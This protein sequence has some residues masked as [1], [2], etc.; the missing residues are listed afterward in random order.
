MLTYSSYQKIISFLFAYKRIARWRSS[1]LQLQFWVLFDFFSTVLKFW[2][3]PNMSD[4]LHYV[5]LPIIV[6]WNSN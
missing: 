2:R 5:G 6:G 4:D 1:S 3:N